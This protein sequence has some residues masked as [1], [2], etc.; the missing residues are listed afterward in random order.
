MKQWS[1]RMRLL[2]RQPEDR[3]LSAETGLA[4]RRPSKPIAGFVP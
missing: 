1:I 4:A 2:I 3:G